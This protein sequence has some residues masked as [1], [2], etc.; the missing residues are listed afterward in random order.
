MVRGARESVT[1]ALSF[2]IVLAAL[3]SFD[4]RVRVRFRGLFGDTA[5]TALSPFGDRVSD[6]GSVLWMAVR[7]QS[8]E[9]GPLLF[10]SA[11]GVM[12]VL[13]MLRMR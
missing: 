2:G 10:F 6:L 4:P 9:N 7:D 1:S 12:L 3:V 11:V 8:I 13:F 5:S